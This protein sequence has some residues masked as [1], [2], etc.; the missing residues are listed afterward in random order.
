MPVVVIRPML[1]V[2]C[3]ATAVQVSGSQRVDEGKTASPRSRKPY[4]LHNIDIIAG[5]KQERSENRK[6]GCVVSQKEVK[7]LQINELC[8]GDDSCKPEVRRRHMTNHA[9]ARA[10]SGSDS[11]SSSIFLSCHTIVRL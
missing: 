10:R 2:T 4:A 6:K 8:T 7:S 11:L 9:M 1:M 3:I 5:T